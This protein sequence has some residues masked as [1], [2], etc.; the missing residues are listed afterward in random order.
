MED[1]NIVKAWEVQ[2][3]KEIEGLKDCKDHVVNDSAIPKTVKERFIDVLRTL[4]MNM[5]QVMAKCTQLRTDD[6]P[7][8]ALKV[9]IEK[10]KFEFDEVQKSLDQLMSTVQAK[11]S[12]NRSFKSGSRDEETPSAV[13][14]DISDLRIIVKKLQEQL[15]DHR[16]VDL[17]QSI[18]TLES[19][20][21]ELRM[22]LSH[23]QEEN[24]EAYEM[25]HN[26]RTR[27]ERLEASLPETNTR[28]SF[29]TGIPEVPK[30]RML[31]KPST[32]AEDLLRA[33]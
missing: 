31:L 32:H 33:T 5:I 20:N 7:S 2:L 15:E 26:L 19:E 16:H 17:E 18:E 6:I 28:D 21:Q 9:R 25:I 11:P 30:K 1:L 23:I 24:T 12:S 14:R 27:V 4:K 3:R 13:S 22:N 10:L 29:K 8:K